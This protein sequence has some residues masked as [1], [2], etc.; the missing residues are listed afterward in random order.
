MDEG[1]VGEFWTASIAKIP[2]RGRWFPRV[3]LTAGPAGGTLELRVRPAPP[4]ADSVR[5]WVADCGDP[6]RT[7]RRKGPDLERLSALRERATTTGA[8][9]ALLTTSTGY[10]LEAANAGL[11]WW[12][13]PVLCLPAR[14]LRV[15][16][17][18]TTS[19]LVETARRLSVPVRYRRQ[20]LGALD[21]RETWLVNALHGIRP[22]SA[23]TNA[24]LTPGP[25]LRV[26][27]W[28]GYLT[29]CERP[30]RPG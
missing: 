14:A 1:Q 7:P 11:L 16:P 23:W 21:G 3:Q 5:V 18:V 2:Q 26:E 22:V 12:D 8:D 28:R 10:V 9:E 17:S 30:V 25:H 27:V 29:E 20:R 19:L 6:R 13:G 4:P 15:L 24:E